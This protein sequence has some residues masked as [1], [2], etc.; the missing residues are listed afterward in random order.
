M[1]KDGY[2]SEGSRILA[3]MSAY[4]LEGSNEQWSIAFMR[5]VCSHVF[6]PYVIA[7]QERSC[8]SIHVLVIHD[9]EVIVECE[10]IRKR[11]IETAIGQHCE[12]H[13]HKGDSTY[14]RGKVRRRK[15]VIFTLLVF[16]ISFHNPL[17]TCTLRHLLSSATTCS[18]CSIVVRSFIPGP[19]LAT[20]D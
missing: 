1:R 12:K 17:A 3:H 10:R 16:F 14:P 6:P 7:P 20:S 8:H 13:D 11:V 18:V 4:P 5:I 19:R 15:R 9:S 2:T